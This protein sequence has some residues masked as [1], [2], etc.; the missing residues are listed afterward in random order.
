MA[1]VHHVSIMF[2]SGDTGVYTEH[3]YDMQYKLMRPYFVSWVC[4]KKGRT[5]KIGDYE[6]FTT[7][8]ASIPKFFRIFF[9]TNGRN[10]E[11]AVAHD[12][13][14][15]FASELGIARDE[16][17]AVFYGLLRLSG[18]GRVSAFLQYAGVRL[19]GWVV[20]YQHPGRKIK[21]I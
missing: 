14:Y 13:F 2:T 9:D 21:W 7:D 1:R 15:Q 11:A 16:A 17:D 3:L 8:F 6:A 19:G 5:I 12:Y 10:A 4:Q 20:F 18:V